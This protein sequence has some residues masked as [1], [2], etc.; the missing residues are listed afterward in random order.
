MLISGQKSIIDRKP[1]IVHQLE[2]IDFILEACNLKLFSQFRNIE[3]YD[4]H[5]IAE[6]KP[7]TWTI[8]LVDKRRLKMWHFLDDNG[9]IETRM[10]SP[11][12]WYK[13]YKPRGQNEGDVIDV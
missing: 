9:N 6:V 7:E 8:M 4:W 12:D 11:R 2:L 1:V 3:L 10:S 13:D 5:R